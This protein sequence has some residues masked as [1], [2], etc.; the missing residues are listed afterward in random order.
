MSA[1][2]A[3]AR[4]GLIRWHYLW[5]ASAAIA[6]MFAAVLLE[7]LWFFSAIVVVMVRFGM[8]V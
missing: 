8:G 1:H 7:N 3:E 2:A 6:V 4:R 5:Y